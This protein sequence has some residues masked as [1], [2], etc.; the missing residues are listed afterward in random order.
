MK[1]SAGTLAYRQGAEGIEVLL[2]H[3]AGNYNRHAPWSIPKGIPDSGESL[4]DA[5]R[6]E[7][8]EETGIRVGKLR[9]MG[10]IT[11]QKSHKQVHAFATECGFEAPHCASWEVDRVEFVSLER[12]RE[13]LHPDQRAFLDRLLE[14]LNE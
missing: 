4:E 1:I 10:S 13:L 8:M 9:P 7:T 5:A 11:Y 3:P 6:R 2:V 14:V 12:A